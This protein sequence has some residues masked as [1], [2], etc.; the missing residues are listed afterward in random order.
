MN[1]RVLYSASG[2]STRKLLTILRMWRRWQR[3]VVFTFKVSPAVC[4][5]GYGT[6]YVHSMRMLMDTGQ[7]Q[8]VKGPTSER[9]VCRDV[10]LGMFHY[11]APFVV[12]AYFAEFTPARM[13]VVMR[14]GFK[15][16]PLEAPVSLV[17]P[18]DPFLTAPV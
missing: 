1:I 13:R 18:S 15:D 7:M 3:A 2:S 11:E 8:F 4:R 17:A 16:T 9:V 12:E 6:T 14:L 5:T 10:T